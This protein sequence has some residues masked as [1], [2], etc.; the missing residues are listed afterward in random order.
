MRQAPL[1]LIVAC[2]LL[3][4]LVRAASA[5]TDARDRLRYGYVT[6]EPGDVISFRGGGA[7]TGGMLLH[8]HSSL[9]L[10]FDPS[11][12]EQIFLDFS[13]T[14]G[15]LPDIVFGTTAPFNGRIMPEREFLTYNVRRHDSFD[16]YRLRDR[17]TLDRKKLF[18]AAKRMAQ[19]RLFGIS[20]TVCSKAVAEVLSQATGQRIALVTPDG[21][22]SAPF[23]RHPQQGPA[24][25][26]IRPVLIDLG[27]LEP[28]AI[29][30]APPDATSGGFLS[31]VARD[32]ANQPDVK[33]ARAARERELRQPDTN[34]EDAARAERRAAA[35]GYLRATMQLACTDPDNVKALRSQRRVWGIV[36]ARETVTDFF[37]RDRQGMSTCAQQLVDA[38][39]DSDGPAD[40]AWI[41][42]QG[43]KYFEA[44]QRRLRD[45]REAAERAAR[46]AR[47]REERERARD[48][49]ARAEARVSASSGSSSPVGSPRLGS[50]YGQAVGIAGGAVGT[51]DGR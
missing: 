11:T 47:A 49:Y 8:G 1:T 42:K 26:N 12:Q 25:V 28:P 21:F 4:G 3:A 32:A 27:R 7:T 16:V 51:F 18:S 44:E 38:M 50:A 19:T 14:K 20:G 9:Y 48:D 36:I 2:T 29:L 22:E 35:W 30:P 31:D 39:L 13:V 17:S 15:G 33:N 10:G 43:R 23:I 41:E 40:L 24:P 34:I 46:V 5:Q 45:E 6:L 37:A